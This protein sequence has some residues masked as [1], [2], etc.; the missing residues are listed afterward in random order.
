MKPFNLEAAK[1]GEPVCTADGREVRLYAFDSPHE[2]NGL[3]SPVIGLLK[4][5]DGAWRLCSWR[6]D[7]RVWIDDP[8][9]SDLRMA[10][11]K[12]TRWVVTWKHPA[13]GKTIYAEA[14]D[15]EIDAKLRQKSLE[16]GDPERHSFSINPIEVTL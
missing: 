10:P 13:N 6:I 2:R 12:E 5:I 16:S 1:H 8:S 14:F 11:R 4:D 9:S 7:G 3:S 15:T